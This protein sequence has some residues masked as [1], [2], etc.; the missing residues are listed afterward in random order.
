MNLTK[1]IYTDSDKR[2]LIKF[3]EGWEIIKPH[4]VK[5]SQVRLNRSLAQHRYYRAMLKILQDENGDT[6]DDWN[7]YLKKK[8]LKSTKEIN[9]QLVE[10]T[11]S[12]TELTTLEFEDYMS[13]IRMFASQEL[14]CYLPQPNETQ[15]DYLQL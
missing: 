5:V 8:F 1:V 15:Y 12:S 10:Y 2:N 7:I 14:G 4:K 3:L 13:K 6:D 11:R 9:G